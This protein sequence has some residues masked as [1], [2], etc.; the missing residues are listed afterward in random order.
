MVTRGLCPRGKCPRG[1]R[2]PRQKPRA[3]G[4]AR[5]RGDWLSAVADMTATERRRWCGHAMSRDADNIKR[6][7][8]VIHRRLVRIIG[9][10]CRW[11]F[12]AD[13]F[14]GV[15]LRYTHAVHPAHITGRRFNAVRTVCW[16]SGSLT[17][18]S[19]VAFY[20]CIS[21]FILLGHMTYVEILLVCC[22]P[23]FLATWTPRPHSAPPQ[24]YKGC[25]SEASHEKKWLGNSPTPSLN[26]TGNKKC[27]I[28]PRFWDSWICRT[29]ICRTG[30]WRSRTRANVHT[31]YDEVNAN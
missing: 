9:T 5:G 15:F 13:W 7:D 16:K 2:D 20:K 29:G 11:L 4:A 24:K 10:I 28:W 12:A 27:E 8:T 17:A 1:C 23:F 22:Y 26:M 21:W 18:I 30:K 6:S 3:E 19:V 14:T 25:R 31:A